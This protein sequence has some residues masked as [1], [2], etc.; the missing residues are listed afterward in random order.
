MLSPEKIERINQLA[1]KK[2]EEGLTPAE[3]K[4]QV[5]LREAYLSAFR[6]GM[7]HHIEGMKVVDPDGN[8]V[9]PE[10]LKE[11]QKKKGLHNRKDNF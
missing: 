3:E 8:D 1:R 11:I 5:Q 4:E 2:K 10:K 7:R 9:T 6:S